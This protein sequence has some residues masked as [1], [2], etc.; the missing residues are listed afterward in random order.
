MSTHTAYA[1]L[2]DGEGYMHLGVDCHND[3]DDPTRDCLL[4]EFD[5]DDTGRY[6]GKPVVGCAVKQYLDGGGIEAVQWGDHSL[7]VR[8]PAGFDVQWINGGE[9][10]AYPIAQWAAPSEEAA[11]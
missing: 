3:P 7:H 2:I 8:L 9:E 6:V 4:L 10:D 5:Y 11:A 1:E